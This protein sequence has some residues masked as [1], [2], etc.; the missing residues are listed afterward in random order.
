[1]I[2]TTSLTKAK[3]SVLSEP[4]GLSMAEIS[5]AQFR[6]KR[7]KEVSSGYLYLL[8]ATAIL[9]CFWFLP[10]LYA[11]LVS[12]FRW[13]FMNPEK[14]FVG[15]GNYLSLLT[16]V[17]YWRV[18]LNT[19]FY[20]VGSIPMCMFLALILALALNEK[21][22]F[23][24]F[25]RAS[26]F[27]PVISCIIAMSAVW[28]WMYDPINGLLNYF[29]QL[30][31]FETLQW[32]SD[33]KTAMPALIIMD[34]W[35]HTGYDM[36]IYLAGIQ[37]IPESYYEAAKIDGSGRWQRFRYITWPLLAPTTLFILII[38]MIKRFQVFSMVHTMT[39]GGPAGATD[40][41]VYYLYEKA[42]QD[43]QMGYAFAV[44]Y[45]LF[46]VIFAVTLI[47]W[48]VGARKVHYAR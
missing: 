34:I 41:I 11:F 19:V 35:K 23:L 15:L 17:E 45:L 22:K 29:L 8:P 10:T 1:M 6:R 18:M 47:Q 42:F 32:L 39:Q 46:V 12:F 20:L 48:K 44:S 30:L 25:F 5:L 31:D 36:I 9:L 16:S 26:I 2:D 24:A 38:S 37:S 13:D 40:V 7:L 4:L 33:T 28:L 43:F 27:A 14:T 21:I 3:P